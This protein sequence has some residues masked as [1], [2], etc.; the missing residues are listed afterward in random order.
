MRVSSSWNRILAEDCNSVSINIIENNSSNNSSAKFVS[1]DSVFDAIPHSGEQFTSGKKVS[2]P[3]L[4]WRIVLFALSRAVVA[5]LERSSVL[6]WELSG[7]WP[8]RSL[9]PALVDRRFDRTDLM[10]HTQPYHTAWAL[11]HF[12]PTAEFEFRAQEKWPI[13]YSRISDR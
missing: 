4:F 12:I 3:V 10:H 6:S 13:S 9:A 5:P 8:R 2:T 7:S 1:T 11:R